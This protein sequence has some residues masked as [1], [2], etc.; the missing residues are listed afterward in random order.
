M[1]EGSTPKP[2]RIAAAAA[3][4]ALIAAA[5]PKT[6]DFANAAEFA[7]ALVAENGPPTVRDLEIV[8]GNEPRTLSIADYRAQRMEC[9]LSRLIRVQGD[10]DIGL[11]WRCG[12][13]GAR[14]S[15]IY[16]IGERGVFRILVGVPFLV[17]APR[18]PT[19]PR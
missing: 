1:P 11:E 8:T 18:V 12:P 13:L 17:T 19:E 7:T 14:V 2:I 9:E 5:P 10:S 16:R 6:A 15:D 4:L 3:S